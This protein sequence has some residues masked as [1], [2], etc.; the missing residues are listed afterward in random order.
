[1]ATDLGATVWGMDAHTLIIGAGIV[2]SALAMHL[3]EAGDD[4][5]VLDPD[6][7]GSLSS[8]ERNA[9]G[10]RATWWQPENVQLCAE[11]IAHLATDA[12]G[13]GLRQ[14]GYL[15]LHGAG[16]WPG[17]CAAARLQ[18]DFGLGVHL[19]APEAI[20]GGWPDLDLDDAVIGAT[21]SPRDGLVNPDAIRNLYRARAQS[22]G[23]RF[24][25]RQLVIGSLRDQG[26]VTQVITG[27]LEDEA[28]AH[29]ALASRDRRLG[30]SRRWHAARVINAAGPWAGSVARLLGY[31]SPACPAPRELCVF[32][33][34]LSLAGRGMWVLDSGCY[35]HHEAGD[36]HLAG[37]SP[38]D[39]EGMINFAPEGAA[40]F[41][42][43]IWPRLARRIPAFDRLEYVRG[44]RG[45]YDLSPDRSA[46][47]GP[48]GRDAG[49]TGT[50]LW[51]IHSFSG[52][53]VM[54]GWA[55]AG[56][57]ARELMGDGAD[58]R[59]VRF[60]GRRFATGG[61]RMDEALHI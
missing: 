38:P 56:L 25:D 1:M 47:C 13:V 50:D 36:L 2:G 37:W 42:R 58:P 18:N 9:G 32:R 16:T 57:L 21:Y 44:W 52:R 6:L 24:R 19:L 4:V 54:Q 17:A 51:E 39:G 22:A 55:M 14:D 27:D 33:A 49:F 28:S 3:A 15:W 31:R 7:A 20:A 45:L 41:E 26:A 60:S 11:T 43:E 5:L 10:V 30:A 35:V 8:S 61:W 23:A 12:N 46:I 34:P 53:G 40:F 48:V 59:R 29:G